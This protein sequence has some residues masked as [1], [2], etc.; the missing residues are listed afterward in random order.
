MI[1][2]LTTERYASWCPCAVG[3]AEASR[4]TKQLEARLAFVRRYGSGS[5]V[6]RRESHHGVRRGT[7]IPAT[8]Y[9]KH[10]YKAKPF[11]KQKMYIINSPMPTCFMFKFATFPEN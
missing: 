10:N 9:Y 11:E 6:V 1:R 8:G 5:Y 2:R 4:W 3:R 7:R